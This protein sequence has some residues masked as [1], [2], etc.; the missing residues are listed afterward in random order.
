[1]RSGFDSRQPDS[2]MRN[3]SNESPQDTREFDRE[4]FKEAIRPDVREVIEHPE[5]EMVVMFDFSQGNEY[6]PEHKIEITDLSIEKV[7]AFY[8]VVL[9]ELKRAESEGVKLSPELEALLADEGQKENTIGHEVKHVVAALDN[10]IS[11][12]DS[13]IELYFTQ[14]GWG[15][16]LVHQFK[17]PAG[18]DPIALAY[19]ALAPEK[20]SAPDFEYFR[21]LI[22]ESRGSFDERAADFAQLKRIYEQKASKAFEE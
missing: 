4:S 17:P 1:M 19:V 12:A 7:E 2:Y 22:T 6:V 15:L 9:D 13:R 5:L 18:S 20:P 8:E 21:K 16:R 3:M 14:S 11:L 10:G